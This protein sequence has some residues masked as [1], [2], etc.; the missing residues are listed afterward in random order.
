MYIIY[1]SYMYGIYYSNIYNIY[2]S[3]MHN[4]YES[5]IIKHLTCNTIVYHVIYA[6]YHSHT[7][8]IL[9]RTNH[10]ITNITCGHF[11]QMLCPTTDPR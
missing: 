4:I 7:I 2:N 5:F 3:D 10:L 1:N 11:V 6:S 8:C 9:L